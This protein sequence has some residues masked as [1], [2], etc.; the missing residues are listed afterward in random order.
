MFTK[1][2]KVLAILANADGEVND[3]EIQLMEKI[4][5]ANGM[6]LDEIHEAIQSPGNDIELDDLNEDDKFDLLHDVIQLMKIDSKIYNEEILYCQN[7]AAKLG[8]PL[9]AV[10]EIYPHVN[11]RINLSVPGEKEAIKKKL[12]KILNR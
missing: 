7:I 10:M 9:E 3:M 8:F 5:K 6:S 2:L 11:T 1:Q 4:G 12:Y